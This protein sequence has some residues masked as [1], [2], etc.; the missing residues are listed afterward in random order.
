M[1]LFSL[2][3]SLRSLINHSLHLIIISSFGF[4]IDITPSNHSRFTF[5]TCLLFYSIVF[6]LMLRN[7]SSSFPSTSSSS[8]FPSVATSVFDIL[9]I[10][11][12]ASP[13]NSSSIL[14]SYPMHVNH[15]AHDIEQDRDKDQPFSHRYIQSSTDLMNRKNCTLSSSS[16][17]I[18][19]KPC[20]AM[21]IESALLTYDYSYLTRHTLECNPASTA[22]RNMNQTIDLADRMASGDDNNGSHIHDKQVQTTSRTETNDYLPLEAVS[23]QD[24][25]T[26]HSLLRSKRLLLI[27]ISIFVFLVLATLTAILLIL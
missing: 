23:V 8:S 4:V 3:L 13:G 1:L 27:S 16:D 25:Y 7:E 15:N 24:R 14:C 26:C 21:R 5:V 17:E 11:Q 12:H 18:D 22:D 2:S 10:Q 9:S 20:A 19:P 6:I